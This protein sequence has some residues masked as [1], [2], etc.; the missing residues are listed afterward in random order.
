MSDYPEHVELEDDVPIIVKPWRVRTVGTKYG[1]KLMLVVREGREEREIPWLPMDLL[2]DLKA[3]GVAEIVKNDKGESYWR[4]K[5]G[6][7]DIAIVRRTK[8]S[9]KGKYKEYEVEIAKEDSGPDMSGGGFRRAPDV[10]TGT[11]G[12]DP[13]PPPAPSSDMDAAV[14]EA[15][16]QTKRI[17][18]GLGFDNLDDPLVGQAAIDAAKS[19]ASTLFIQTRKEGR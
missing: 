4:V 10:A 9:A 2:N 15:I 8:E 1:D 6:A 18:S 19:L 3:L 12:S 7:P 5:S 11:Q 14:T 13:P 16:A 17:L